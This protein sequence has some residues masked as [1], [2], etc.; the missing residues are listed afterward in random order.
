MKKALNAVY[1][2]VVILFCT[3]VIASWMNVG[4]NNHKP[5]VTYQAW[6]AVYVG[7]VG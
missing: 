3:W 1:L 7:D 4:F 6:N 2:A 5:E